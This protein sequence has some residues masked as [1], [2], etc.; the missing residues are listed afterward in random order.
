MPGERSASGALTAGGAK[1]AWFND[2]E[3]N[4]MAIIQEA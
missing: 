1:A 2:S 3:G 4:T